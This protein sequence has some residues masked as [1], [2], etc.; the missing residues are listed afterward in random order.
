MREISREGQ[1][2][3]V[4]NSVKRIKNK[5]EEIKKILPVY[6]KVEIIHGQMLA[7]DIKRTLLDFENGKIDVLISTI[8]IENGIDIENANTMIIDGVEKLGLSQ[9]YQLRGR[10]GRS[11]K[12]SYCYMLMN[13]NKSKKAQKREESIKKFDE[14][15]GLELSMEDIKI[16]GVGEIL[17]EKQHGAVETF[18]YNLYVKMLKEEIARQAGEE[19]IEFE[20][21]N[22]KMNF[23]KYIPDDYIEKD[24]KLKF[25]R[26]H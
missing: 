23:P 7:R 24:E 12:Q 4:Y 20:E 3:Y 18:G 19:K 5:A 17:G 11:S 2:F 25:I 16:R 15:S 6:V 26:K 8:I 9:V 22:I 21:I 14:L 1:V 10:I 13:D